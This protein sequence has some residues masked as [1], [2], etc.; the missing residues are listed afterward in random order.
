MENDAQTGEYD[1]WHS[2]LKMYIP[3]F[4]FFFVKTYLVHIWAGLGLG[5]F[6]STDQSREV[7]TWIKTLFVPDV[8]T[9]WILMLFV[10]R[11]PCIYVQQPVG[12]WTGGSLSWL[13]TS[14]FWALSACLPATGQWRTSP[15]HHW[16]WRWW[17]CWSWSC[18]L[19]S[20]RWW[21][22]RSFPHQAGL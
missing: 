18:P 19:V 2:R 13:C 16:R 12:R 15:S 9:K 6:W 7:W 5:W 8:I 1:Q 11:G 3:V 21:S 14:G 22:H 20:H 10:Y 4:F 17:W